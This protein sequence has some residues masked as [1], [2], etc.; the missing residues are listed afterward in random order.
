MGAR[1]TPWLPYWQRKPACKYRLVCFPCGGGVASAY[2]DWRNYL[3]GECELCSVELPG[4]AT[5]ISETPISS[6]ADLVPIL[7]DALSPFLFEL[8]FALFGHSTGAL[9]AFELARALRDSESPMPVFL[10][11]ASRE[12]PHIPDPNPCC[13]APKEQLLETLR[14][15][16]G[17]PEELLQSEAMEI[18]LPTVRAD[19]ALGEHYQYS[20]GEPL[21]C[22]IAV[23]GGLHD[24]T[25][26]PEDL[27][28]WSMHT[29]AHFGRYMF[30]GGHFFFQTKPRRVLQLIIRSICESL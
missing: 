28:A 24:K 26:K 1:V 18:M 20:G 19:F 21:E 22:P 15:Y 4:R 3:P 5:R 6:L 2:E 13:D 10:F 30:P 23:L 16:G 29:K 25:C 14:N 11:A 12:A 27:D 8:P 7:F 9:V 17:T